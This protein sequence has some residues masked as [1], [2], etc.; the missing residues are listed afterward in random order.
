MTTTTLPDRTEPTADEVAVQRP[1][2]GELLV[3]S[4]KLSAR[5]L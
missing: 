2:I 5:D 1:L 3:Q 4:G